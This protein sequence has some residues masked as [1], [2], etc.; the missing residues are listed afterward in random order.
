MLGTLENTDCIGRVDKSRVLLKNLPIWMENPY[1]N[2]SPGIKLIGFQ[3]QRL[4]LETSC[5]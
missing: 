1:A 4:L 3:L 2:L 5:K